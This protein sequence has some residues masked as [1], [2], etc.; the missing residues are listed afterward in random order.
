VRKLLIINDACPN[1]A[2]AG[3][4]IKAQMLFFPRA[5]CPELNNV[6]ANFELMPLRMNES[7]NDRVGARQLD[8]APEVQQGRAAQRQG[9]EGR[10]ER[11]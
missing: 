10:R 4:L 5:V 8:L 7:K 1:N 9:P 6:I 2:T 3:S 11:G